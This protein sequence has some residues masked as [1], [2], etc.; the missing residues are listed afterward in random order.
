MSVKEVQKCIQN[1]KSN[2]YPRAIYSI[3]ESTEVSNILKKKK[4]KKVGKRTE[5]V[6]Q[7]ANDS[8]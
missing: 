2:I 6:K 1:N 3:T 8:M 5:K 4:K 7:I